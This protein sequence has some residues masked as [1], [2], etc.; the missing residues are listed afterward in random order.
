MKSLA[1]ARLRA[2]L[3]V[4]A[5]DAAATTTAAGN[6]A[7][8]RSAVLH[9]D[10]LTECQYTSRG[11]RARKAHLQ[12]EIVH[13]L[14]GDLREEVLLDGPVDTHVHTKTP[15]HTRTETEKQT[16][17]RIRNIYAQVHPPRARA[18]V[19]WRALTSAAPRTPASQRT[20]R[21]HAAS[22]PS[23]SP[24]RPRA[25]VREERRIQTRIAYF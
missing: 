1:V 13:E 22:P 18:S 4:R 21:C 16:R 7:P 20:G 11:Q 14:A 6:E 8:S 2:L 12:R 10:G 15:A 25:H 17:T 19:P 5:A 3:R 24:L 9:V 23:A